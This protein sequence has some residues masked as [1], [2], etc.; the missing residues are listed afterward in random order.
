[1][2]NKV[3][4]TSSS[5]VSLLWRFGTILIAF[6]QSS[7]RGWLKEMDSFLQCIPPGRLGYLFSKIRSFKLKPTSISSVGRQGSSLSIHSS[8]WGISALVEC[9]VGESVSSATL[10][11]PGFLAN[12]VR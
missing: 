7:K 8:Y 3:L 2:I 4:I 12:P 9:L 11:A 6:S 5:R 10:Y 1:M